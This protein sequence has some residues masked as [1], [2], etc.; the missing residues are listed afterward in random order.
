MKDKIGH[1]II[2]LVLLL[3]ISCNQNIKKNGQ[4][5]TYETDFNSIKIDSIT[6][7]EQNIK[8]YFTDSSTYFNHIIA[9]Q[10]GQY[11]IYKYKLIENKN[12]EKISLI[13]ST[14]LRDEKE[15]GISLSMNDFKVAQTKFENPVFADFVK[16]LFKLNKKYQELYNKEKS[17]LLDRINS[18]FGRAV[19]EKYKDKI[20]DYDYFFGYD[21]YDVF[22]QYFK[23]CKSQNKSEATE[24][25]DMLSNDTLYIKSESQPEL[26]R[27]IQKYSK[28]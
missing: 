22:I 6:Y 2:G 18:F 21:S 24:F 28:K 8:I 15:A 20:G 3:T 13:F 14:P 10:V 1:I 12:S 9:G 23:D 27:L 17:S 25:V 26:E 16:E 7:S 4:S 19:H 5:I 11:V